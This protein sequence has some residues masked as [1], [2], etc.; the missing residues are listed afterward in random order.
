MSVTVLSCC[1]QERDAEMT[2]LQVLQQENMTPGVP[3]LSLSGAQRRTQQELRG[4]HELRCLPGE[5]RKEPWPQWVLSS[6]VG[7]LD[8]H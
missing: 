4:R 6:P 7:A 5:R 1:W 3:P 8:T 2:H